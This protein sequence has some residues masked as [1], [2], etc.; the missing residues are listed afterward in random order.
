MVKLRGGLVVPRTPRLAAIHT[1]GRALV[2]DQENDVWIFR[3]DPQV[4][5]VIA[6]RRAAQAHPGLAAVHRAL[7]Y[8][9]R[10]VHDV[11]IL[12]IN[13]RDGQIAAADFE[14]GPRI[15]R[16][17]VPVFAGIVRAINA[18]PRARSVTALMR[19][20]QCCVK[21]IGIAGCNGNLDVDHVFGQAFC[22]LLPR[23]AAIGGFE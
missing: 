12:R 21:S 23:I 8:N 15:V 20:G 7:R 17:L 4:L 2:T 22:Q 14:R 3:I 1:N 10:A 9:A 18:K 16:C 11:W 5:I 19:G 13:P 6:A